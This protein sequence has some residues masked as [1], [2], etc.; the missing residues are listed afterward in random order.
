M[1]FTCSLSIPVRTVAV[2]AVIPVSV[3]VHEFFAKW[4]EC[5][6]S[7]QNQILLFRLEHN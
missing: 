4:I 5:N 2:I 6:V 7:L 3:P 1:K